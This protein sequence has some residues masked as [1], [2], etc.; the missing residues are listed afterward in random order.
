MLSLI[1][2][3]PQPVFEINLDNLSKRK[4][5]SIIQGS[6]NLK[7]P[8]YSVLT[9]IKGDDDMTGTIEFKLNGNKK[10]EHLGIRLDLIG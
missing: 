6:N 9:I 5:V 7:L 10:I 8:I 4:K 1:G 3:G 2:L